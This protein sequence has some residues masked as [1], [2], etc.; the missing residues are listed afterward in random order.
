MG[1]VKQLSKL[2]S[3]HSLPECRKWLGS[4]KWGNL[5]A[6]LTF[7]SSQA[8][9]LQ[10]LP[11]NF[12]A[13]SKSPS[14]GLACCQPCCHL[15]LLKELQA[16]GIPCCLPRGMRAL[17]HSS[18]LQRAERIRIRVWG[19]HLGMEMHPGLRFN[20]RLRSAPGPAA[21]K[22]LGEV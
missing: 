14:P 2:N 7:R 8:K 17:L 6:Q 12:S 5:R 22:G 21:L 4:W 1:L 15:R 9:H 20:P 3:R 10:G 16:M 18:S 11:G 19:M 13:C